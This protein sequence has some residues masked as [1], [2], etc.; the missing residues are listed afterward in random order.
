MRSVAFLLLVTA[1]LVVAGLVDQPLRYL[2][3]IG[4]TLMWVVGLWDRNHFLAPMEPVEVRFDLKLHDI[5]RRVLRHVRTIQ[6]ANWHTDRLAHLAVL[7]DAIERTRALNPP[8]PDWAA[9][10]DSL[11]RALIFD[12]D[13]YAG[14][15]PAS[16]ATGAASFARWEALKRE[17]DAVRSTRA[18]FLR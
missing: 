12:A 18:R 11:L 13:V 9:L 3:A 10:R 4:A 7:E 15:R 5:R 1:L 14:S 8:T 16:S 6:P 2:I 17:W